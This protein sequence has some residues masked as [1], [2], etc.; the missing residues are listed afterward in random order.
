[1][2]INN[3]YVILGTAGHIDHGKSALVKAL[4][5]IDPDRLKE[6]KQRGMTIDLGFANLKYSDGLTVGIVDVP[7]HERLIRNMLAGAGSI[8]IVLF[9]IAADEGIMPQTHEHLH[10]CNILKIQSGIIVIT[11]VDLVDNEWLELVK[12]EVIDAVR[13]TFLEGAEI[14]SVSSKT[15]WNIELL[16]EKIKEVAIKISPKLPNGIFRLPI[17]RV[18]TLKGL[19]T[20]V[21][22]TV[23]SGTLSIGDT[24]E[25]LPSAIKSKVR[26]LHSHGS[27]IKTAIAGQRVAINLQGVEKQELKRGD[28]VVLPEKLMPSKIIDANI[29]L[30]PN[31]PILKNRD[32]VHLYIGTSESMARIVLYGRNEIKPGEK[33]YCQFR[34]TDPIVTL[35]KDRYIIRRFSPTETIGGG[36]V[37][38][39]NSYKMSHKKALT[40]LKI[41]E[42]GS[43]S[44]KLAIKI[45]RAGINGFKISLLDGWINED[46]DNIKSAL[47]FLIRNNIV[48]QFD[49][50]LFHNDNYNFLREIIVNV[51]NKFH[52][53]NPLKLGIH[54]EELKSKINIDPKIFINV[55]KIIDDIVTENDIVRLKTFNLILSRENEKIKNDIYEILERSGLNPPTR[56]ELS[57]SLNIDLKVLT[58]LLKIMVREE[59]L[60]RIS[61]SI[62]ITPLAKRKMF[63]ILKKFF[64]EKTE[65]RLSEFK[66]ITGA[67]RKNAVHF[68]EYL[69]TNKITMRI[70]EV[71]RFLLQ[72]Q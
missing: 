68:V 43:L 3:R 41:L 48:L 7:G 13:G 26:G 32:V 61:D 20:V 16:K 51:V 34:L 46:I 42:K 15:M 33:C 66:E 67:T 47:D 40:D 59:K 71:R 62:Y 6:E 72:Q 18:F 9:V 29:K 50:I 10:I 57:K 45:R 22:G 38:D 2:N 65:M 30:L 21:T 54:K 55:L 63:E 70:G 60:V 64:S 5:G 52:N 17:D 53:K 27:P 31:A 1:M 19:G 14:V 37:L 25:I 24:V 35:A 69:D 4:T 11:K 8:D 28:V 56:E 23:V 36:E 12:S 39:P 49:D 58:D 44:E